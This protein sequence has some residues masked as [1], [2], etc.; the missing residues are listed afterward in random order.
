MLDK[1]LTLLVIVLIPI[2]YLILLF[3]YLTNK[4]KTKQEENNASNIVLNLLNNNSSINL[5]ESKR[6][7]FSK[8]NIQRKMV[9]LTSN[10]YDNNSYFS[11]AIASLLS[12]YALINNKYLELIG[13][14]FN[15]LKFTTFSPLL[16]IIINIFT[17]NIADAKIAVIILIIIAIYQFMLNDI[18]NNAILEIKS[19]NIK[20][21]K[22]L[23]VME[24]INTL[25]FV[26]TL[27]EI[28]R[29][30]III[31]RI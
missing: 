15:E 18:N 21:N 7:I 12:G 6:S 11:Q 4:K 22:I 1:I 14:I 31:L 29:L 28:L 2:G 8:Y 20:V 16:I 25:F 9:K 3:T 24:K 19:K 5:I 23:N 10:T 17:N 27:I 30:V 26:T 13:K